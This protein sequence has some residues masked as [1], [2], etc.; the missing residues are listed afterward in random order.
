MPGILDDITKL[1]MN[2]GVK[3]LSD[4]LEAM[5]NKV[6]IS[7]ILALGSDLGAS[8]ESDAYMIKVYPL[9]KNP[10]LLSNKDRDKLLKVHVKLQ[11]DIRRAVLG[12]D[13]FKDGKNVIPL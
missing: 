12:L 2:P 9:L 11:K 4:S 13:I 3:G 1:G 6:K 7:A 8:E 10:Q 5:T